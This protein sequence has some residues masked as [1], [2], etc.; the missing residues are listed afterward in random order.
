MTRTELNNLHK[1]HLE[2]LLDNS[3]TDYII[4]DRGID[5]YKEPTSEFVSSEGGDVVCYRVMGVGPNFRIYI[6]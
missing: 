4:E 1:K 2:Y 5:S 6:H 3:A